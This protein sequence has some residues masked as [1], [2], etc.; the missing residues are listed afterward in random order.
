MKKK[1]KYPQEYYNITTTL[2]KTADDDNKTE[3]KSR[4]YVEEIDKYKNGISKIKLIDI[5]V[6]SGFGIFQYDYVKKAIKLKFSFI[7]NTSEIEWLVSENEL[8]TERKEKLDEI[9]NKN[10]IQRLFSK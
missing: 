8:K 6:L 5:E 4:V 9:N 1:Q 10:F 7:K 3:Y 2:C